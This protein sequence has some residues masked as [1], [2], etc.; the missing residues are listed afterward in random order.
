[1]SHARTEA[2]KCLCVGTPVNIKRRRYYPPDM[3][4]ILYAMCLERSTPG[5]MEGVT[6]SVA[7]DMGVP[8]RDVQ[9][10]WLDGQKGGGIQAFDWNKKKN[11]DCK[12]LPFNPDVI[13]DVP[14]RQRHT[15]Q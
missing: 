13:I 11:C 1:M 10:V 14:L 6:K 4:R 2:C 3:K 15:I 5:I 12:K 8:L 9:R 7:N